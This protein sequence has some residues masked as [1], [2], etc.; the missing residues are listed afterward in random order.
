[1]VLLIGMLQL[2]SEINEKVDNGNTYNKPL[3]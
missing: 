2:K 3:Q 1:M